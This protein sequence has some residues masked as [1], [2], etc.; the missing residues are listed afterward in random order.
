MIARL[1]VQLIIEQYYRAINAKNIDAIVDVFE[2]DGTFQYP[3]SPPIRGRE[4]IRRAE[5]RI[6]APIDEMTL[7][8]DQMF[9]VGDRAAVKFT[10]RVK[11]KNGRSATMEGID[12]FQINPDGKIQ[13]V[14][15][16][17]DASALAGLVNPASGASKR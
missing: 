8:P 1:V 2:P 6:L 17:Y 5:E 13:S 12:T 16:Y 14:S 3:E 10:M 4:E 7:T 9:I 11:A 15:V